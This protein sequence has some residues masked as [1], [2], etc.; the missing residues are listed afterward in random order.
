MTT[1]LSITSTESSAQD[2]STVLLSDLDTA[3]VFA[4][5][6]ITLPPYDP[7]APPHTHP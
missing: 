4:L 6:A 5:V 1:P 3:G 7:G 2:A